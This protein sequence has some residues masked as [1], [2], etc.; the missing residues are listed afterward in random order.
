MFADRRPSSGFSLIELVLVVA[1]LGI[2]AAAVMLAYTAAVRSSSD[3][4]VHKQA[5]AAAE[6]LVEEI[7]LASYSPQAGTGAGACPPRQDFNDV[8]DYNGYTTAACP[9]LVRIDGSSIPGMS[10]YNATVAV[11][12]TGLNGVA[13]AKL[14]TVTVTGPAGV[15]ITLDGYRVNYP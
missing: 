7:Q 1:V 11:S 13:E 15:T 14:I 2:A 8:D 6:A 12:L 3:P 4:I 10:A 5:L 9:G